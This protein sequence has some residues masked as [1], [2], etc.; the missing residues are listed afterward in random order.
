[1][2][3]SI[4]CQT[5]LESNVS[6]IVV[7]TGSKFGTW[8]STDED[9][10]VDTADEFNSIHRDTRLDSRKSSVRKLGEALLSLPWAR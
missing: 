6:V 4:L 5:D 9:S 8:C 2:L 7:L 10:S 1:M 3:N